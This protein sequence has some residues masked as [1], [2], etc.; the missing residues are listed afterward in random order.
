MDNASKNIA[1]YEKE[2]AD[3]TSIDNEML[4]SP[5]DIENINKARANRD[6]AKEA[7]TRYSEALEK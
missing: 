1:K 2:L 4:Y 6:A 5:E 3:L 7:Y